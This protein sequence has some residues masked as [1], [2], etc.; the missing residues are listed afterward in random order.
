MLVGV[1][2]PLAGADSPLP[3][4]L[5]IEFRPSGWAAGSPFTYSATLLALGVLFLFCF[6]LSCQEL[7]ISLPP[8]LRCWEYK[9]PLPHPASSDLLCCPLSVEQCPAHRKNPQDVPND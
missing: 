5:V 2:E 1:R 3:S 4:A 8:P 9:S 7:W 6:I